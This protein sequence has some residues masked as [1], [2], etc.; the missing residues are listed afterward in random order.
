MRILLYIG[1]CA[2]AVSC[3]PRVEDPTLLAQLGSEKLYLED[4]RDRLPAPG[5]MEPADSLGYVKSDEL[6]VACKYDQRRVCC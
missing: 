1:I 5:S 4:L 6:R 2:L 3:A